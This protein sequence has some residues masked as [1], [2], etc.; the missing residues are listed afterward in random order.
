[1]HIQ[2]SNLKR[3][4]QKEEGNE[5]LPFTVAYCFV[6]PERALFG[7]K[8]HFNVFAMVILYFVLSSV[9]HSVVAAEQ[10][11]LRQHQSQQGT[12][13]VTGEGRDFLKHEQVN[14]GFFN[15][16]ANA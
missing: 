7:N 15:L 8:Q 2:L 5:L 10:E 11:N 13:G 12:N 6:C 3:Q 16:K 1:M 14:E 4:L 9:G